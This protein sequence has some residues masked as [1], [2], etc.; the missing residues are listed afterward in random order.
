MRGARPDEYAGT[1]ADLPAVA[2]A[3]DLVFFAGDEHGLSVWLP[4]VLGLV[5]IIG[6]ILYKT[7]YMAAPEKRSTGFLIGGLA[8]VG[9]LICALIGI[10]MQLSAT[11]S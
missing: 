7:G 5:W 6:R 3:G 2:L 9:L 1:A 8:V 11:T 4:P 10:V